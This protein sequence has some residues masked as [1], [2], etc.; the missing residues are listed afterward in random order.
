LRA[1]RWVAL[2]IP[3]I[4]FIFE[5]HPQKIDQNGSNFLDVSAVFQNG[6]GFGGG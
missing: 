5:N 4:S 6:W 1:I 3:A 2:F